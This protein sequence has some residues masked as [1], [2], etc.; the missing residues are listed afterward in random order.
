MRPTVGVVTRGIR[1]PQDA[2]GYWE[3]VTATGEGH[4]DVR[5][6]R[7]RDGAVGRYTNPA[8]PGNAGHGYQDGDALM[9]THYC[10]ANTSV[11][12]LARSGTEI[13]SIRARHESCR[14]RGTHAPREVSPSDPNHFVTDGLRTAN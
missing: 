8:L 11:A 14:R 12:R 1:T 10:I 6:D 9:L 4:F 5:T 3:S 2:A 13:S 7:A